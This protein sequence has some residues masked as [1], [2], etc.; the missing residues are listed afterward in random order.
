[1]TW[2]MFHS[3]L[4]GQVAVMINRVDGGVYSYFYDGVTSS[5]FEE[6]LRLRYN[7]P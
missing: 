2:L 3:Y 5:V 7:V 4:S 6:I 1:M